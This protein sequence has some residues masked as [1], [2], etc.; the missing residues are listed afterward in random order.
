MSR[1]QLDS[2]GLLALLWLAGVVGDVSLPDFRNDPVFCLTQF[3]STFKIPQDVMTKVKILQ[4]LHGQLSPTDWKLQ[5]VIKTDG[6]AI[7]FQCRRTLTANELERVC[8][9]PL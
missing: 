6:T 3:L 7:V 2:E 8:A 1:A 9:L 4:Q 5:M